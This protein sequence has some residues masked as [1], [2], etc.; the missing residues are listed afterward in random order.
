MDVRVDPLSKPPHRI[1][2]MREHYAPYCHTPS[3]HMAPVSSD[4][5]LQGIV[6]LS[7]TN[8]YVQLISSLLQRLPCLD[9][10]TLPGI[11]VV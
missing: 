3:D 11:R 9:V 10:S 1:I 6:V 2:L 7:L 5:L 8:R 4:Y